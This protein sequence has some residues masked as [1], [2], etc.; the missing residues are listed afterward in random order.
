[1]HPLSRFPLSTELAFTFYGL[2]MTQE[3]EFPEPA[4]FYFFV[5]ACARKDKNIV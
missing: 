3:S 1:M 2:I 4:F 5:C